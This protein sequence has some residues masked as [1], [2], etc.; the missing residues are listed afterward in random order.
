MTQLEEW[1]V[2]ERQ[3]GDRQGTEFI[4]PQSGQDEG[5]IDQRPFL[6]EPLQFSLAFVR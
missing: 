2:A 3:I 6:P 1:N 4:G 5:L